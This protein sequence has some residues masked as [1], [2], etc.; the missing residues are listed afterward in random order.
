MPSTWPAVTVWP[1]ATCTVA[2]VPLTAKLGLTVFTGEI[3]PFALTVW[4][5]V[6]SCTV[7]VSCVPVGS[8]APVAAGPKR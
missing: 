5:T 3:A 1:T 4:L 7:E 2:I 8:D 6:P